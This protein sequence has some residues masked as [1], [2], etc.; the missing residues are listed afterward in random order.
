MGSA[1]YLD[2]DPVRCG[3][4]C[5]VHCQH[6]WNL[7]SAFSGHLFVMNGVIWVHYEMDFI[8]IKMED[9]VI[10]M[11]LIYLQLDLGIA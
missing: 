9:N 3:Q 4:K 2:S 8:S 1:I 6:V 11:I 5:H 10:F 7:V